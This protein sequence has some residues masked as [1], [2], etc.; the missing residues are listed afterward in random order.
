MLQCGAGFGKIVRY[1]AGFGGRVGGNEIQF[2]IDLIG[3]V[4]YMYG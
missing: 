1:G 2:P 3:V 4:G